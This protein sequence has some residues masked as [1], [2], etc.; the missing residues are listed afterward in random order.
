MKVSKKRLEKLIQEFD[1][2][3]NEYGCNFCPAHEYC[4]SQKQ[5][6]LCAENFISWLKKED[7]KGE[8]KQ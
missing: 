1:A 8:N 6:C 2:L 7:K 5:F 3:T 4:H